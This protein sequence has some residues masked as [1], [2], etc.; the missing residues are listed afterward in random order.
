VPA[1][2]CRTVSPRLYDE[3][4][5]EETKRA[6]QQATDA[7]AAAE[8]EA[9]HQKRASMEQIA[10]ELPDRVERTAKFVAKGDP[11]TT[12][13]VGREG[14][15]A[16][17]AE[18]T[19]AATELGRQFVLAVNDLEWPQGNRYVGVD[20]GEIHRAV[21]SRFRGRTGSLTQVLERRGYEPR[22]HVFSSE[23]LFDQNAFEPLAEALTALSEAK[24]QLRKAKKA[25]DDS[26]VDDL[27]G[28]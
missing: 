13:R 20:S 4:V 9:T 28:E 18:L 8:A 3:R 17:R 21:A 24:E 10:A 5:T 22:G 23:S 7:H 6:L 14:V 25:D 26:N 15:A 1:G 2:T 27:W 12:S 19:E 16:M 11:D